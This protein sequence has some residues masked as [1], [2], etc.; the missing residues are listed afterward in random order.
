MIRALVIFFA[1]CLLLLGQGEVPSSEPG[2]TNNIVKFAWDANPENDIAGYRLHFGLESR[3]YTKTFDCGIT[4]IYAV[5]G[6]F[7]PGSTWFVAVT[8]YNELGLESDY[9]NEISFTALANRLK[10]PKNFRKE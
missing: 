5:I 6:H 3:N 9:S 1:S 7:E 8:A 4:T 10:P 2:P